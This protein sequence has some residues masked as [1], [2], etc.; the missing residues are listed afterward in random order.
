MHKEP[1]KFVYRETIT[2][3]PQIKIYSQFSSGHFL[4]YNRT[5]QRESY[6]VF[7]HKEEQYH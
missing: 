1:I 4:E 6:M 7:L 2:H 3:S 5:F